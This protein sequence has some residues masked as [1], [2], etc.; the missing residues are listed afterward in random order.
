MLLSIFIEHRFAAQ[1]RGVVDDGG[2][3]YAPQSFT[4]QRGRQ[5]D[6]QGSSKDS[7]VDREP[8]GTHLTLAAGENLRLRVFL[9]RSVIEVYAN[10]RATLTS[11][12]YPS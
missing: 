7:T 8:H 4:D 9:D 3:F 1:R 5:V 11:R 12:V 6:R 2:Y 10:A